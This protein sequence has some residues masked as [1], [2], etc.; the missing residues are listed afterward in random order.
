[1]KQFL[2]ATTLSLLFSAC[3]SVDLSTMNIPQTAVN[4]CTYIYVSD[5]RPYILSGD[6]SADFVGLVRGG[7]GNPFDFSTAS[8]NSLAKDLGLSL[9]KNLSSSNGV[10][11][12]IEKTAI[13]T[14]NSNNCKT[15]VLEIA[16]WKIDSMIDAWFMVDAKLSIYSNR[17]EIL[18]SKKHVTKHDVDGSFWAPLPAARENFIRESEKALAALLSQPEVAKSLSQ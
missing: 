18:A 11:T 1:M 12:F 3:H 4:S 15:V 13:T 6:K 2:L 10:A 14:Q 5:Q 16:E 8:G 17:G 9:Q 7:Y